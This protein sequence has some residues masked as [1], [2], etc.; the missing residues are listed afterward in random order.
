MS[1]RFSLT[2][3]GHIY[4]RS[5]TG[6]LLRFVRPSQVEDFLYEIH[7]GVY[8]SHTGGKSLAHKA[9]TQGYWWP[10]M[11]KDTETYARKCEK[12]QR[13][14]PFIHQPAA[15]LNPVSRPWPF[16]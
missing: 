9:I 10:Y 7:E 2:T 11:Q 14:A 8:G 5:F 6:S 13:F 4:R 12:C 1:A 3:E 15:D 16:A